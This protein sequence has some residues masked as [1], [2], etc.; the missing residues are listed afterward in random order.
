MLQDNLVLRVS[1]A[2]QDH[3]DLKVHDTIVKFYFPH[4]SEVII[5]YNCMVVFLPFRRQRTS[6]IPR[7]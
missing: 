1:V 5:V 3:L 7:S 4:Y 2:R 6:W